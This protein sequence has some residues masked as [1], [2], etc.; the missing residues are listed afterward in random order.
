MS[1]AP[2]PPDQGGQGWGQQP[3][4]GQPPPQQPPP[5]QQGGWGQ[6]PPPPG[7]QPPQQP[8]PPQQGGWGQQ[9]PQ[10]PQ[11]PWGQQPAAAPPPQQGWGAQ[12]QQGGWGAQPS[13]GG[14]GGAPTSGYSVG[15]A[16]NWG[17]TKFQQN[18][19]PILLGFLAII[20]GALV[21][22]FVWSLIVG[23][24]AS[25]SN[26]SVVINLANGLGF[27]VN[28]ALQTI[29]QAAVVR[30]GLALTYGRPIE[31]ST[32]FNMDNI[33][34]IL[35]ASLIIGG[36][37]F[38]LSF[39][40][41]FLGILGLLLLFVTTLVVN[42]LTA[43]TV[44]FIIDKNLGAVDAIKA[45]AEFAMANVGTLV[46]FFIALIAAFIVGGL[47]CLV[48]LLVAIPVGFLAQC[49]TYRRLQGEPVAP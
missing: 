48:G 17:W 8:P 36:V 5:P 25:S 21:V 10:P 34:T 18:V 28:V 39:V 33:V 44:Y 24:L 49:Y 38:V 29:I 45:S 19:G 3:G 43:W 6:Q 47:A 12:P 14:Y 23:G 7:G 26:S 2:P 27:L 22:S 41:A 15:D 35:I 32:L 11:Q 37:S 1:D 9:P 13:G 20:I 16:F 30:A 31:V 42:F 4:W 40:L 46:I